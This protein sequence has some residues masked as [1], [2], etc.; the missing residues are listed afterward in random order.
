MD[1]RST[2]TDYKNSGIRL[3]EKT[4]CPQGHEYSEEN[5]YYQRK[6]DRGGE[7]RSRVCKL[8]SKIRM[9]QKRLDPVEQ[10]RGRQRTARWR[11]RHPDKYRAGYER[12]HA[13]K[14]QILDDARKGGCVRCEES[15]PSCLDFH[16]RDRGTKDADIATMRRF[17]VVRLLAE[18]AKCDVLCANCHR[19]HHYDERNAVVGN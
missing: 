14:K 15:H 12:S 8:C 10:E 4:H 7:R 6:H 3:R 5:T 16:H 18:I 9:Q 17:S 11:E 19:K 13:E 1:G 2:R